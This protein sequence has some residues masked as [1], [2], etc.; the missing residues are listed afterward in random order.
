MPKPDHRS[1]MA[2]AW[3]HFHTAREMPGRGSGVQPRVS[4]GRSIHA[5]FENSTGRRGRSGHRA[6]SVC[7]SPANRRRVA[8]PDGGNRIGWGNLPEGRKSRAARILQTR[9]RPGGMI[10]VVVSRQRDVVQRSPTER[11]PT[12]LALLWQ[13]Y[14]RRLGRV[15][16]IYSRRLRRVRLQWGHR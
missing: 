1:Q 12:R 13:I 16:L 2:R 5:V 3:L 10:V 14:S 6:D 15:R 8:A 7:Q 4:T 9:Q 11:P